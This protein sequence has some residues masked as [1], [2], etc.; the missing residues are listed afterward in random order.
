MAFEPDAQTLLITVA[1]TLLGIPAKILAWVAGAWPKPALI[2]F[3]INTS[4]TNSGAI[5]AFS[6]APLMAFAPN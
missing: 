6:I 5:P 3:P 2:T 1:G 4:C